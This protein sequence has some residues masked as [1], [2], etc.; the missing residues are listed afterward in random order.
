MIKNL[1]PGYLRIGGT[2]ADRIKFHTGYLQDLK[3]N[4]KQNQVICTFGKEKC[5]S[6]NQNY[7][8]SGRIF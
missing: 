5:V 3:I 2:M 6:S 1:S 7:V 4:S 8:L